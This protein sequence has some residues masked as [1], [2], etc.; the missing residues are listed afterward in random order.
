ASTTSTTNATPI[1]IDGTVKLA[2]EPTLGITITSTPLPR[3]PDQSEV[4]NAVSSP[5]RTASGFAGAKYFSPV[6]N[7]KMYQSGARKKAGS[8]ITV[9]PISANVVSPSPARARPARR[10]G[11]LTSTGRPVST[12][13]ATRSSY[14]VRVV[15]PDEPGV[16]GRAAHP[17]KPSSISWRRR[18][19]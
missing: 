12:F 4:L 1:T 13:D 11:T 15:V 14:G 5:F 9:G 7:S 16:G 10:T 2:P 18:R 3:K 8:K 6:E 17:R 19:P